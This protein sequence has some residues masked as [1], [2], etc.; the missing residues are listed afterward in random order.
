MYQTILVPLDGSKR[1]E[2]ILKHVEEL[3]R[4]FNA[5][6]IFL[7]VVTAPN[8]V[9]YGE[10]GILL[11]NHHLEQLAKE[12]ESYL[13][14]L[15]GEFRE[16]GIKAK[17]CVVGGQVVGQ[18]IDC[19]LEEN[20]DLVAMSSHGRTGLARAFYGSVTAGVLNLIDRPLLIIRS[21]SDD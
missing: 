13:N 9:G 11:Y 16:K 7:Q 21:R 18:I 17:T 3:A 12:A 15:K 10:S 14:S 5:R 6:V 19:A 8:L 1:A 2:R 20:A 4:C